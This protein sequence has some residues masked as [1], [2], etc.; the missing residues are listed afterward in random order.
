[1]NSR[2]VGGTGRGAVAIPWEGGAGDLVALM[3]GGC[4]L[5]GRVHKFHMEVQKPGM[6]SG[7]VVR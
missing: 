5:Y 2:C 6:A 7:D 3:H 4:F 1:M